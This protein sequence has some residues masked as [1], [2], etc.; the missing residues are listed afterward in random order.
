MITALS[1]LM[2]GQRRTRLTWRQFFRVL[3]FRC[4]HRRLSLVVTADEETYRSCIKCGARRR[5]NLDTW[6]VE[7]RFYFPDDNRKD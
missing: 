6:R 1:H 3:T 7:G 2:Q 4:P 5:F